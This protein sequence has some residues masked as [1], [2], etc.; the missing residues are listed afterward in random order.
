MPKFRESRAS[1]AILWPD[2]CEPQSR[3]ATSGG[4]REAT[5]TRRN[6]CL[7]PNTSAFWK[8]AADCFKFR[9]QIGMDV[10]LGALRDCYRQKKTTMNQL[11]EAADIC[12]VANVMRLYLESLR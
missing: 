6:R 2:S 12:R 7:F 10:A 8:S 11:G 4:G 9:N 3:A 1:S 5:S